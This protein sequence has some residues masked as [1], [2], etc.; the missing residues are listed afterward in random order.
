MD[1]PETSCTRQR[2]RKV[3]KPNYLKLF[4]SMKTRGQH[5]MAKMG[6][7]RLTMPERDEL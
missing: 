4:E 1:N 2:T 6:S 7:K 3:G 5:R